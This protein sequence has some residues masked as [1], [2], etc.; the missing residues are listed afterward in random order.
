M[1]MALSVA[2]SD[3][4][5]GAGIQADIKTFTVLGVYGGAVITNLTVQNT[6]GVLANQP[7]GAELV[8][9]QIAGVLE[10]MAV[11]H[12]KIGM[13][14]TAEIAV[15]VG[16]A[17]NDFRGEIIFDPVLRATTGQPLLEENDLDA[18]TQEVL[19]RSTV[20]I[21]NL[22]ELEILAGGKCRNRQE[23]EAAAIELFTRFSR[24]RV[25]IAK[26]GHLDEQ[27]EEVTDY[28][29]SRHQQPNKVHCHPESHP[30]IQSRNT[31]GTGCT[32]AAAF[33]AFHLLSGDDS[34]A[35]AKT[36]GFMDQL[37]TRSADSDLGHG[38]GPLLHHLLHV[39]QRF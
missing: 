35:F 33:T 26:G 14:G 16:E 31:H 11:S 4:S 38:Q 9:R 24:L 30:R 21:P 7:V 1:R 23:I 25:I 36:A 8:K 12:V 17:L 29:L 39:G 19:M 37:L 18:L 10:D 2:G 28:L 20:L 5:G 27:A 6:T 3:P 32:F 15:A 13:V 34:L 22:N